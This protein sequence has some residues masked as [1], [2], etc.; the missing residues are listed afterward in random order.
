MKLISWNYTG[1]GSSDEQESLRMLTNQQ[2]SILKGDI[3]SAKKD[4]ISPGVNPF[5]ECKLC[6]FIYA[7]KYFKYTLSRHA[8]FY[9]ILFF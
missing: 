8:I 2:R 4:Q 6:S 9:N 1:L 5:L 7:V 3:P